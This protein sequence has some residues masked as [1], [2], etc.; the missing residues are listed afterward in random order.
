MTERAPRMTALDAGFMHCHVCKKLLDL[1]ARHEEKASCSRCS[2]H[3]H[4][5]LPNSI[6]RTW[7]FLIASIIF[8]IP[9]NTYPIMTVQKLGEGDGHTIIGGIIALLHSGMYPI[10]FVV[11]IASLLVP[12]LKMLGI[13]L[14]LLSV[15]FHWQT[16]AHHRTKAYRI[17]EFV[18]RWSM[19]D[20]FMISI[21]VAMVDLGGVAKVYAGTGA[22][23]FAAVVI[24]TMLAAISFDSRLIWD[25][26]RNKDE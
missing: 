23:A 10:A 20:V 6:S 24:F 12:L 4:P 15:Q 17:I 3:V 11:F 1:P 7:A 26:V 14:L 22:T 13:A 19:L 5:R 8:Y 18:G 9:A 16:S 2:A 25:N 21:L